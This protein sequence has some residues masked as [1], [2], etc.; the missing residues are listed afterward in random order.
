MTAT[1]TDKVLAAFEKQLTEIS[2]RQEKQLAEALR[3]YDEVFM[4]SQ[5]RLIDLIDS[6]ATEEVSVPESPPVATW[7]KSDT[8]EEMLVMN[9]QAAD[10]IEHLLGVLNDVLPELAKSV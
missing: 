10:A 7:I 6:K 1:P 8:G 2:E 4:E 9:K 3:R 5:Q